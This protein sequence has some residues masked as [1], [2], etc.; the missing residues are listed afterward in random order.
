MAF[1]VIDN[2]R[3]SAENFAAMQR[4]I[5][6]G[7]SKVLDSIAAAKEIRGR[8]EMNQNIMREIGRA[9]V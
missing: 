3:A 7:L 9:H 1:Q 5:S 4:S 6:E 8:R 2:R